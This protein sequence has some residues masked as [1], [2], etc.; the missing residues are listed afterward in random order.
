MLDWVAFFV[1]LLSFWHVTVVG[2]L[3]VVEIFAPVLFVLLWP[4]KQ[5]FI[6]QRDASI[7][8]G[9]GLLWL[10]GQVGTDLYRGAPWPD[11]ARGWAAIAVFLLLFATLSELVSAN[12]ARMYILLMGA[13][14]GGV[15]QPLL[16]PSPYSEAEP[17][18]FG[19]GPPLGLLLVTWLGWRSWRTGV[20][21]VWFLVLPVVFGGLSFSLNARALGAFVTLSGLAAWVRGGRLGR[22]VAGRRLSWGRA[23]ALAGLALALGMAVLR[24]YEF[25]VSHGWL[26]EEAW[27]KYE[28]QA[29]GRFGLIIGGRADVIPALLAIRESPIIGYGS[30][31]KDPR[32]REYLWLLRDLGYQRSPAEL[33]YTI[34]ESD[35]I[36][37]HSHLLQAWVWAGAAGALFWLVVLVLVAKTAV[38]TFQYRH[39][40]FVPTL[41]LAVVD[42]W[43]IFF[44]PFGSMM[45][46]H[47]AMSLTLFLLALRLSQVKS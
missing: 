25:A 20:R 47:W 29:T 9:L 44:S 12:P 5:R 2:L 24:T 27:Q 22:F 33:E 1:G 34:Q 3:Y 8:I 6:L 42:V 19:F 7:L 10:T 21:R 4:R 46:F 15:L 43:N 35:V 41:Y 39:A 37:A 11:L 31:A 13:A 14:L 38:R 17:W 26:G 18:K 28:E 23:I 30:W 16:Q 32:Y 40:L 36:P 45:R